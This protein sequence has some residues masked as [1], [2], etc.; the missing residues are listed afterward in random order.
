M[1]WIVPVESNLPFISA[2]VVSSK[3]VHVDS[4][5]IKD[6]SDREEIDQVARVLVA[7]KTELKENEYWTPESK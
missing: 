6:R 5:D 7:T 3:A 4:H 2:Q 1:F